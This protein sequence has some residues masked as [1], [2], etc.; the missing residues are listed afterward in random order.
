LIQQS[1]PVWVKNTFNPTCPGTRITRETETLPGTAKAVTAIGELTLVTVEGTGML[2]V[3]GVAARTF[4]AVASQKASILMISQASSEQ[5]I[6]FVI[7]TSTAPGVIHAVQEEM[8]LELQRGDIDR[9][10]AQDDVVIVTCVGAG[11]RETPGVAARICVAL[12]REGINI[13]A[14]AQGSS[15]CSVSIVV[16]ADSATKAVKQIHREVIL[17]EQDSSSSSGGNGHGGTAFCTTV[18]E[19]S[20]V[21][22]RR[23]GSL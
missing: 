13:V 16:P 20:L 8:S 4:A 5:S 12:A 18:G 14:I 23:A 21:R 15:D 1:I 17:H 6:C 9:V 7:P 22:D 19:P 10:W 2:G 11:M 3:P